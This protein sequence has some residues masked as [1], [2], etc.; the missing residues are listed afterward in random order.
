MNK[1]TTSFLSYFIA[2]I[3][4]AST[5]VN[6]SFFG[7]ASLA[8]YFLFVLSASLLLLVTGADL[9]IRTKSII[10][11][12]PLPLYFF[13]GLV[14]YSIIHGYFLVGD[15]LSVRHIY[16]IVCGLLLISL[17]L[18]F[19]GSDFSFILLCKIVMF[20]SAMEALVCCMQFIGVIP[21]LNSFFP[22]T[23]TWINPN[24]TAMFFVMTLPALLIVMFGKEIYQAR[25]AVLVAVLIVISLI[26]LKCRT[27]FIGSVI[28]TMIVLN[29]KYS[30]LKKI[31]SKWSRLTLLSLGV[32]GIVVLIPICIFLYNIKQASADGRKLIWKV[33]MNM[34]AEKPVTGY[35]Y[36]S[37]EHHYNLSQAEYLA[38]GLGTKADV[39]NASFV[40]M[41]Y[42]EFL[43]N[44]VEGGLVGLILIISFLMSLLIKVRFNTKEIAARVL[45]DGIP[46]I[47]HVNPHADLTLPA[48]YGGI[49]AFTI[50]SMFNFTVQAIPVMCLLVVY[51]AALVAWGNYDTR[52]IRTLHFSK[53]IK[54]IV[55]S[56]FFLCG[57]Y[58]LT[59]QI[60]L[61]RAFISTKEAELSAKEGDLEKGLRTLANFEEE[62]DESEIYWTIY[63]TALLK[64]K[65]YQMALEKF[66]KAITLTSNPNLY[67][68]IGSC[69]VELKQYKEAGA[70]YQIASNIVPNRFAPRYALM[71]LYYKMNDLARA[72]IAANELLALQ[73]KVESQ[74]VE[75]YKNEAQVLLNKSDRSSFINY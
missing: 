47:K 23:G 19:V 58:F 55:S 71:K 13:A 75:F 37:F 8:A 43:E 46:N 1:S 35:G 44:C 52:L 40:K 18:L 61:S 48:C 15:A 56:A 7:S 60:Y 54:F 39:M 66:N 22:V 69:N 73:P 3:T 65:Q 42:N 30:L 68:L 2:A 17:C 59:S 63:G 34:I 49:V 21:S 14:T 9:L 33:S 28:V 6:H 45:P 24:V 38:K 53:H 16:F 41:A 11:A 25:L 31:K 70:A 10:V 72:R 32:L 27:A 36:G 20:I 29:A 64:K 57:L 67:M 4:I 50:M 26:L 12:N 5:L 51:A 74:A 62:M